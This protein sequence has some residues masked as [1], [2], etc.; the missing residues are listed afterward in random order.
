MQ[1]KPPSSQ[2]GV[3]LI[4]V[5]VMLVVIGLTSA[6]VMRNALS[7]DAVSANVR[8][9]ALATEAA[10]I[11]L[12]HCERQALIQVGGSVPVQAVATGDPHWQT[13]A[14]WNS[15][16]GPIPTTLTL[17]QLRTTDATFNARFMP[18][19]M[20]EQSPLN[21]ASVIVVTAR[22]F[23]PD[24]SQDANRRAQT[25]SVVWLQSTLRLR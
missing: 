18:Q 20:V 22:G 5:L 12:A 6:S 16:T 4:I 15:T 2:Q 1:T 3:V 8:S 24:Y 9:E 25:G 19:C 14:N 17:D 21:P 10:Q 13:L 23:S 11:A 7:A